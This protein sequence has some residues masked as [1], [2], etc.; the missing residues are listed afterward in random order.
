M[1]N[2]MDHIPRFQTGC[3]DIFRIHQDHPPFVVHPPVTIIEAIDRSIVLIVATN[4]H[5]YKVTLGKGQVGH[6]VHGKVGFPRRR[7]ELPLAGTIGQIEAPGLPDTAVVILETGN[8]CFHTIPDMV[9]VRDHVIP[10][11]LGT[12]TERSLGQF[13]NN[14][15]FAFQLRGRWMEYALRTV[16]YPHRIFYTYKLFACGL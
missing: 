1:A 9:V 3:L 14:G 5:H 16:D 11:H 13:R 7:V 8:G 15:R 6:L 10:I 12:L 2:E 4:G